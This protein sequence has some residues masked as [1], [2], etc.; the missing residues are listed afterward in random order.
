MAVDW[1]E[2]LRSRLPSALPSEPA[3][4]CEIC[5][6]AKPVLVASLLEHVQHPVLIVVSSLERAEAWMAVL[7]RLG[8]PEK[9]VL[10][11]P[12]GITPL[13]EPTG[14]ELEV[15]H[16]R[17]R[18]LRRL[19]QESPVVVLAPVNAVVQR[20]FTPH[21]FLASSITLTKGSALS[22]GDL[23]KMLLSLGYEYEEPVRLPGQFAR[24]GGII[25]LFPLGVDLPV[26][27]EFFGDEI[28]SLRRFEPSTQRSI[29][30]SQ[31]V[32]ISPARE[33]PIGNEETA[34]RVQAEWRQRIASMPDSVRSHALEMLEADLI[35]L[36]QGEPFDR[37]EIYSPWLLPEHAC[38][39]DYLHPQGHLIPDEP[40]LLEAAYNR[41]C[42][43]LLSAFQSRAERGDLIPL[44]PED[45][46]ETLSRIEHHP[47]RL[48]LSMMNMEEPQTLPTP[49]SFW[50]VG[51]KTL[52]TF[53]GRLPALWETI[54]TWRQNGIQIVF[55]TD[56]P[57]RVEQILKELEIP[58]AD[59]ESRT[60]TSE[61]RIRQSVIVHRGNLG[62]GFL[63]EQ[64]KF[65]LITDAELF[66]RNRLRLPA[67]TFNEGVPITSIMD[68]KP[69][70]FVV[71]IHHGIGIFRGLATLEREGEIKEYLLIE[72]APPDKLYVP[73]DQLDRVQKYLAPDDHPPGIRR[74][75]SMAWAKAVAS[76]RK[77]AQEVAHE[78]VKIYA[79][80]EK[81]TRL[82]YGED[83]P[84]QEE[85]E[86]TFPY[87][88]T[89]TQLKAIVD[90]KSDMEGHH[91]MDRLVCGDVGFG[92][93]E[94]A[95]RAAF[96]AMLAGKQVAVLCPTTVLSYQ[97]WQT[98]GDRFGG[99]PI[100]VALLSRLLSS[101]EQKRTLQA[102]RSGAVDL[103][104]GTHRLLSKD[105]QFQNLGL[106]IIDEEQRFGVMQKERFKQ[107]RA[108]VDVLT[109]SATPIPRTLYMALTDVRDMSLITDP[110]PG[111]LPI[112]TYVQPATDYLI[113]EAILRELQRDGQVFFVSNRIQGLEHK[114]QKIKEL[115][116]HA[117]IAVAHGQMQ[118]AEMESIVLGFYKREY[119]VLVC[120][121]IIE[122]GMDMPN[123]NTLIVDRA[124]RFGL[125]Q[126]YQLRGRVGRS[127]R[128]AYSYF[129][130]QAGQKLSEAALDRLQALKEFSHLGSGFALAMRDMEIRGVGNLLGTEQHGTIA[131]VGFELYQMMLREAIQR[132]RQGDT[133]FSLDAPLQTELPP[134]KLPVRAHLPE[135]YIADDSQRLWYYKRIA[136]TREHKELED[137]KRE[138]RDRYG[139]LPEP[140]RNALR[141]MGLRMMALALGVKQISADR[142]RMEI[143]MSKRAKLKAGVQLGLQKRLK[144]LKAQPDKIILLQ[145]TDLLKTIE[146]VFKTMMELDKI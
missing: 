92:K 29:K 96:K 95:V 48:T 74:I 129:L 122:N 44:Q 34:H 79:V 83:T 136:G 93:T 11:M 52:E 125:G 24:R 58:V 73:A 3:E 22:P 140:A 134:F 88:E 28:D 102:I 13:M 38:A 20:T 8:I 77:K 50:T 133:T 121:T 98:F 111:R 26:R 91:P 112:R 53:R 132:I 144:G 46:L 32:V 9:R 16:E 99:Y 114:A 78:L 35:A 47:A 118:A 37:L 131:S 113:R 101:K 84:W 138:L 45:Y 81:A 39:L 110:P 69:G 61:P 41:L 30:G 100:E 18:T 67:R 51:A 107:L 70:D 75:N 90:V 139:P 76:A 23:L 4:W 43:E 36:R 109:L 115:V 80:R 27:I 119:D 56:Q 137:L 54:R 62:G 94:V 105:V 63:W 68:L 130:Y 120:T 82:P 55:A 42:E 10:C 21:T 2:I 127:D 72:Y 33:V 124:E 145:P 103:V 85:M 19:Q 14:I 126:L 60:P 97:H 1:L 142:Y 106:V 57:T 89:P 17:I 7:L 116:P 123:V 12:S 25:D 31:Q 49:P 86:A 87:K 108:M 146:A 6:E 5:H 104:V 65:A 59:S 40:W 64:A 66:D 15:R 117:R 71:H 141:I 128:Q 143:E 135:E